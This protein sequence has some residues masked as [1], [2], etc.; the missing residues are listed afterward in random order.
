MTDGEPL[1]DDMIRRYLDEDEVEYSVD[2]EGNFVVEYERD[3]DTGCEF[4]V[5]L[6][7][8]EEYYTI[9]IVDERT[10][11]L[12]DGDRLMR[13]CNAWNMEQ[14]FPMA[15]VY[16]DEE[17]ADIADVRLEYTAILRYATSQEQLSDL[18]EEILD[19][20]YEFWA[21]AQNEHGI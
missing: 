12:A 19:A 7:V 2:E 3:E 20:A 16:T 21:W 1:S 18:T 9:Q 14:M 4:T 11:P 10:F 17:N 13:I 5:F 8:D 15:Y 6:S